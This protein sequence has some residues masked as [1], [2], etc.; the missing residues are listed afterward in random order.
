MDTA[1]YLWET[2]LL[3]PK[4]MLY[5]GLDLVYIEINVKYH[6]SCFLCLLPSTI[7]NHCVF[8]FTCLVI[9]FCHHHH[10]C[11]SSNYCFLFFQKINR[12]IFWQKMKYI[13]LNES[14][15]FFFIYFFFSAYHH[16]YMLNIFH[17]QKYRIDV[18]ISFT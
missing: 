17:Q 10:S 5:H 2:L 15:V 7:I 14:H 13:T 11:L 16:K 4:Q 12:A 18:H 6:S 9:T 1:W 8:I 3:W